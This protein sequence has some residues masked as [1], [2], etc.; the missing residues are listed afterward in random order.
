MFVIQAFFSKSFY[1][2]HLSFCK[3][4]LFQKEE[5][6]SEIAVG[7]ILTERIQ[8]FLIYEKKTWYTIRNIGSI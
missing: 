7:S 5:S 1:E 8:I 6:I 4:D 2:Q 3:K